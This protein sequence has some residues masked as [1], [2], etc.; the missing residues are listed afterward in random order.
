MRGL[1]SEEG[2]MRMEEKD[3]EVWIGKTR[4]Y[5]G[6]DNISYVTVIGEMDENTAFKMQKTI[7]KFIN[8]AGKNVD[9]INVLID[10]NNAGKPSS[11]ARKILK[12][13]NDHEKTGKIAH[14]G[15]HPVAKVLA[16]FT[17]G[18]SKN[19]DMRFFKTKEEAL[20]WLK[21]G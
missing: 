16:N 5:L 10:L 18:A 3:R 15:L 13:M 17:M 6:K 11:K 4:M 12:E 21:E 14:F 19:R 8:I 20:V 7:D 2:E 9:K 1:R